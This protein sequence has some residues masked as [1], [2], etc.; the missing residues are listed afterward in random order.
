MARIPQSLV[1]TRITLLSLCGK[2]PPVTGGYSH[3]FTVALWQESPSHWWI[4]ASLYCR[5]VARIPQSLVDT[6]ITLLSLCGKNPPVTGG[7][8]HHFT[9]AL[10]Q[11]S[12]SHWWISHHFTVALWQESPSHWWI[13][14]SLYCRF[15]ARIPQSLVDTRI[16]LLSLC[17]KNPPVTGGYSHHFTVALWQESPSHWW[18]HHFTVALWQESPSHWWILASLYCRF[19]A[20]IPQS[21]VDTRITLLSLCGK[22]PPVT[23]GYSH[24]F[25]VALW[26]ESPSHWW[27][28]ASLYY[29]FVARVPQ[30]LVDTPKKGTVIQNFEVF[31]VIMLHTP[32]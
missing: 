5:F 22:N 25:T 23:G 26:Q 4:L 6:R 30:S 10:W 28:L 19:V 8:S 7:Y 21:L 15:V 2:N 24:H 31:L 13:L 29:R 17:G 12:P 3:H 32:S 11:E 20:R 9:V 16:T 27:I 14:A 18:I 1:D